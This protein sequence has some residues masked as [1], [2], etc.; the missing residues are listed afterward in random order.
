M[1]AIERC[2]Y[3]GRECR[4]RNG[5]Y[6]CPDCDETFNS[7]DIGSRMNQGFKMLSDDYEPDGFDA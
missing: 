5:A 3:C 1:M 4:K 2:L 7:R 6:Y